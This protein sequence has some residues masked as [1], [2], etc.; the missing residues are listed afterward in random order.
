MRALVLVGL[1]GGPAVA[2]SRHPCFPNKPAVAAQ[3][4]HSALDVYTY[5]YVE[6]DK[7]PPP[8]KYGTCRVSAGKVVAANGGLV[9]GL[10]CGTRVVVPGIRDDYGLEIGAFGKQVLD[11]IQPD[12]AL[13]CVSNGPRQVRCIFASVLEENRS[14][15]SY[16]V[17]G[18]LKTDQLTGDDARKFFASRRLVEL[19][20]VATCH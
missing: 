14:G 9:A 19:H 13:V 1:L 17:A 11:R 16:V 12:R 6:G 5:Q 20:V 4:L 10:G 2:E 15:P 3:D 7:L 18:M 8:I